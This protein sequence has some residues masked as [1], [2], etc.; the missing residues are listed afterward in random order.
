MRTNLHEIQM[1][2]VRMSCEF[3]PIDTSLTL[4]HPVICSDTWSPPPKCTPACTLGTGN[5]GLGARC[6]LIS[7]SCDIGTA[8][9][10]SEGA[11]YR[12]AAVFVYG[13]RTF[14]H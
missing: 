13:L 9:L 8:A 4:V 3:R 10:G 7:V 2:F 5:N 11:A 1:N 6:I 12:I 14:A